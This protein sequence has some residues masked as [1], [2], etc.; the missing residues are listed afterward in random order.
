MLSTRKIQLFDVDL[1]FVYYQMCI[2]VYER[3]GGG[4]N[5]KVGGGVPYG[6][7]ATVRTV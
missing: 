6:V 7:G 1:I 4:T 5:L 2:H 3:S